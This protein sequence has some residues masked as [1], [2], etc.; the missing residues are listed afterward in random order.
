MKEKRRENPRDFELLIRA[1]KGVHAGKDVD[2]ILS[3]YQL[4][5]KKGWSVEFLLKLLK[6]FFA[7]EDIYYWNY[8]GRDKLMG[9]IE[10]RLSQ[11]ELV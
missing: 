10:E 2:K 6:W 8:K 5:F 7:L 4:R 1:V 3:E 11:R 9:A